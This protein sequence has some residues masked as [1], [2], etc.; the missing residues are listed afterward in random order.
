VIAGAPSKHIGMTEY[1]IASDDV[2]AC[3]LRTAPGTQEGVAAEA[4]AVGATLYAAAAGK[5]KDTSTDAIRIALEEATALNDI[6]EFIDFTVISTT[7]AV[8]P[9][10]MP[11]DYHRCD[12][13]GSVS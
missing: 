8:Y 7:A 10:P 13:G 3:A 5:L 11:A 12:R 6:V 1:A 2:G 9:W 4:F